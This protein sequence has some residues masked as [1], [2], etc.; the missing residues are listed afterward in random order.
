[1]LQ[2]KTKLCFGARHKADELMMKNLRLHGTA[3]STST[4]AVQPDV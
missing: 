3:V 1:M 2:P 4:L